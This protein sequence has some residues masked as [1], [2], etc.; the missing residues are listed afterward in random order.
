MFAVFPVMQQLHEMLCYLHEAMQLEAAKPILKELKDAFER[1]ESLT[2][3]NPSMMLSLN[4]PEHRVPVNALLL[5]ISELER[6]K[7]SGK[8]N[9]KLR[10]GSDLIGAKLKGEDLKGSNFRGA[11]LIAADLREADMRMSDF[12]GTDLRDADLSGA[13]LTG[14]I[15]LTQAQVNSAKGDRHT[16]LP[17]GL[18]IPE[19]WK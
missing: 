1:I 2:D 4:V 5:R 3:L 12:I 19:H 14:S 8:R 18:R 15:F 16:K 6:T 11:L 10:R 9:R 7:T 17:A 13:K